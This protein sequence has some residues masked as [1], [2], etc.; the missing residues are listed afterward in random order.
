MVYRK[1]IAPILEEIVNYLRN[2][3]KIIGSQIFLNEINSLK[4]NDDKFENLWFT[5][6]LVG[7]KIS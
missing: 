5:F 7:F 6:E 1:Y 3:E 4:A 2:F